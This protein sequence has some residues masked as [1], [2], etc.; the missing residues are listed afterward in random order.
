MYVRKCEKILINGSIVRF[1][2]S[3]R[4]REKIMTTTRSSKPDIPL[5]ISM[6]WNLH[7]KDCS[8]Q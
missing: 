6:D 1:R 3:S 8:S 5:A 7:V 2:G 4:R